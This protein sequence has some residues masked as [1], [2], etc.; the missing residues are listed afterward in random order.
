MVCSIIYKNNARGGPMSKDHIIPQ[1]ILRGFSINPSSAKT[2]QKVMVY[3]KDTRT[4]ETKRIVDVYSIQ[5]FNSQTTER[6]LAEKYESNVAR[7]FQRIA[8]LATS[9]NDSFVLSNAEYRLLHRFFVVMWRRNSIHMERA[10]DMGNQLETM[11]KSLFGSH[12]QKMLKPE[13][14]DYSFE[15][16]FK[17]KYD[18]LR[19]SFYEKV[20]SE[21]SDDDP[22]V[23]KTLEMYS[24]S[25]IHNTSSIHFL[26][27]NTYST[28]IYAFPKNSPFISNDA[29]PIRMLFPISNTL[30]FDLILSEEK[31]DCSKNE[32]QIPIEECS[33]DQIIK[34]YYIDSYKIPN[35]RS[36]IVDKT[37]K[38]FVLE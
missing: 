2:N 23:K 16:L 37:N 3:Y 28:V 36:Y 18:D 8:L 32:Y 11:L 20:V 5:D 24:P 1:F 4:I 12:Y 25:I 7:L 14:K 30:C 13:Y 6:A 19:Q 9:K 34:Q 38:S 10:L 17:E 29:N 35:A 21:T 33:K 15:K 26:L 31:T 27:H 22:T